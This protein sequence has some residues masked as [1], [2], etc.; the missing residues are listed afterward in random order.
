V[1]AR[2]QQVQVSNGSKKLKAALQ[3]QYFLST[4]LYCYQPNKNCICFS[5]DSTGKKFQSDDAMYHIG[6]YIY[7]DRN[8]Q[9]CLP[10]F[11]KTFY[12]GLKS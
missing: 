4:A 7:L 10:E 2:G 8:F 6:F 5:P 12:L 11:W 1:R 9:K 3:L